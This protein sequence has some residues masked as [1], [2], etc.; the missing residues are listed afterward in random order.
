MTDDPAKTIAER[1]AAVRTLIAE[2][3]QRDDERQ[4]ARRKSHDAA[5]ELRYAVSRLQELTPTSGQST[6]VRIRSGVAASAK[7]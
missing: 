7:L 6:P 2:D 3:E 5:E 4:A 1:L